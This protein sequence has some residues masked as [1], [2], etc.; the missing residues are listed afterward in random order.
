[1]G[2]CTLWRAFPFPDYSFPVPHGSTQ[3]LLDSVVQFTLTD[4]FPFPDSSFPFPFL[5]V[6]QKLLDSV[7]QF[8]DTGATS[9]DSA[10]ASFSDVHILAPRGR[11]EVEMMLSHMQLVGQAQDFKIRCAGREGALPAGART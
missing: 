2:C 11:F 3:K 5:C 8:T 4:P 9:T 6:A 10:A 1:M 7:V